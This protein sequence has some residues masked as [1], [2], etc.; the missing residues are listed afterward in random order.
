VLLAKGN[1]KG[2]SLRRSLDE[3]KAALPEQ[4]NAER[5]AQRRAK[6]DEWQQAHKAGRWVACE[7]ILSEAL[8]LN[9]DDPLFLKLRSAAH[10]VR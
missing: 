1:A 4:L 5:Q 9:P 8:V 2:S 7:E 6:L 3:A 10:L